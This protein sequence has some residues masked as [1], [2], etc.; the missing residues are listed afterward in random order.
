MEFVLEHGLEVFGDAH[1]HPT[2]D[3]RQS[4]IDKRNPMLPVKGHIALILPHYGRASLWSLAG[5]GMYV[6]CGGREWQPTHNAKSH[7]LVALCIW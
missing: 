7:A 3:V 5:V 1:T 6:F 4:W 2:A